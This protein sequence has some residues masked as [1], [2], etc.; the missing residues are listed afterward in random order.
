MHYSNSWRQLYAAI[1]VSL[2][3]FNLG[4]SIAWSNPASQSLNKRFKMEE[5]TWIISIFTI[6]AFVGA[7][8]GGISI[9]MVGRKLTILFLSG[10]AAVSWIGLRFSESSLSLMILMRFIS[11]FAG[12]GFSVSVPVYIGEIAAP[13]RRGRLGSFVSLLLTIGVNAAFLIGLWAHW[14]IIC[15]VG[16]FIQLVL[17]VFMLCHL[18]ESPVFLDLHNKITQMKEVKEWLGHCDCVD[19]AQSPLRKSLFLF[20]SSNIPVFFVK[21]PKKRALTRQSSLKQEKFKKQAS[22]TSVASLPYTKQ[23]VVEKIQLKFKWIL[24]KEAVLR[25]QG[26]PE[27]ELCVLEVEDD[28]NLLRDIRSRELLIPIGILLAIMFI[29]EF[30]GVSIMSMTSSRIFEEVGDSLPV[31]PNVATFI[32]VGLVQLINSFIAGGIVDKVGRRVL[33]LTGAIFMGLSTATLGG[34]FYLK[35][36][37]GMDEQ[38]PGIVW[39]AMVS[40]F[41]FQFAFSLSFGP[42]TWIIFAELF[43]SKY[44]G[45]ASMVASSKWIFS[46]ITVSMFPILSEKI[47]TCVVFWIMAGIAIIGS[48]IL[49]SVL[50]ETKGLSQIEIDELFKKKKTITQKV[51][52]S[53]SNGSVSSNVDSTNT[54]LSPPT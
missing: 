1:I 30:S 51:N 46:F 45:Y 27:N 50:P 12:G 35:H 26:D 16:A 3:S 43:P 42:V 41:W 40:C 33:L 38:L 8:I 6:G 13:E 11:G 28:L 47:G 36:I 39:M 5:V 23:E 49:A 32:S 31:A 52:D 25:Y 22:K 53:N 21:D 34:F 7:I 2:G 10:T 4:M 54:T 9:R 14:T 17:F 44:R 29:Y 20:A 19:C 48:G 18:P 15:Y 24:G 37:M